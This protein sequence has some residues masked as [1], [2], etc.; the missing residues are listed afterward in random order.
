MAEYPH[1]PLYRMELADTLSL[2]GERLSSLTDT[3]AKAY[4]TE[5]IQSCQQLAGAFP[6]VPEYQALLAKSYQN[7]A[8]IEQAGG[9]LKEAEANLDLARQRLE[10]L[11]QRSPEKE[12]HEAR[13]IGVLWELAELKRTGGAKEQDRNLLVQSRGLLDDAIARFSAD[14]ERADDPFR[15]R[16]Q[17]RLYESLSETLSLLGDE[18][19]AAAAKGKVEH[20]G[21]FPFRPPMD[22]FFHRFGPPP[23]GD[24]KPPAAADAQQH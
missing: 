19:G 18:A 17:S 11:V 15:R 20:H 22:R 7:L 12:F 2:A 16:I 9:D 13:L 4:L 6:S 14:T 8:R 21:D 5:A 3:E 1:K 24:R 23:Q 10:S